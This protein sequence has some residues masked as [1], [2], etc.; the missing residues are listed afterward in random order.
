VA[1]RS[2]L[3][4]DRPCCHCQ[5]HCQP[6]P[7]TEGRRILLTLLLA[8]LLFDRPS[9]FR[10]AL[11]SSTRRALSL[12]D[13]PTEQRSRLRLLFLL[14]GIDKQWCRHHIHTTVGQETPPAAQ[15]RGNGGW[16]QTSDY[17]VVKPARS[18][19]VDCQPKSVSAFSFSFST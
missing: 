2:H 6:R 7:R 1:I 12:S 17:G 4:I 11:G 16:V 8:P 9:F 15:G 14:E 10:S 19:R 13:I 5:C 3:H 18:D